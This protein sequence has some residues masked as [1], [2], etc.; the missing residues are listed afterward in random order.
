[1]KQYIIT[2]IFA[3]C[4]AS[5]SQHSKHWETLTKA[6]SLMVEKPDSALIVLR[7]MDTTQLRSTEEMAL[8]A[9]LYTQA[10]DKNYIDS[11]DAAMIQTAVNFYKDSKDGYH[12]MLSYYYLARI[13]QNRM[14]YSKAIV[15]LLEAEKVARNID[16]QFYLGLIYRS[17]TDVY[18]KVYNN[19][20]S[21]YYA[22]RS[23]DSFK[24]SEREEYTLWAFWRLGCAYHNA[25]DY[26]ECIAIMQQVSET[27]KHDGNEELYI[28]ALK[29][30][31]LSHLALHE[32]NDVLSIYDVLK[33]IDSFEMRIDD[34]QN[35]G[36]AYIGIG[37]DNNA[38]LCMNEVIASDSTLQW[39]SYE[40]NKRLGNY[41]EALYALENEHMFQDD[42]LGKSL[43]QNVTDAVTDYHN[44]E[45]EKLEKKISYERNILYLLIVVII[46]TSAF[47]AIV[48]Y[49]RYS[50]QKKNIEHNMILAES[51]S[52]NLIAK[53]KMIGQLFKQQFETIGELC[54]TYYEFHNTYEE[55]SKIHAK[56]MSIISDL[57]K[58][59]QTL[60]KLEEYVNTYNNTLMQKFRKVNPSIVKSESDNL[61][62]LYIVAGFSSRT[63]SVLFDESLS[64]IYN[65]K[66]RLKKRIIESNCEYKE[67]FLEHFV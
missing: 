55:K 11:K 30:K 45:K 20:E 58:D 66:A 35:L 15:N 41:K 54:H 28:E 62:F 1:M 29:S 16:E 40:I 31:A 4:L 65:R 39:L 25:N 37:D 36:L 50:F 7:G 51:L 21:L 27:T 8:Y 17:C 24:K 46:L 49:Y 61:L 32:Y 56:V 44:S 12:K 34:Y 43:N 38:K 57:R 3:L 5:C 42:I 9:L 14:D 67:E 22:K 2:I 33:R 26:K 60:T 19:V 18:D 10:E 59:K 23:H 53:E 64:V 47:V 6:E 52:E 63:I 48:V 13:E